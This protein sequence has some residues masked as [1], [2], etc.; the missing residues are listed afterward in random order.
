MFYAQGG[1]P[2][3]GWAT[4]VSELLIAPDMKAMLRSPLLAAICFACFTP[5]GS[6]AALDDGDAHPPEIRTPKSP[7]TPRINGPSIFGVRPG[8]FF[9]YH[10]PATGERP[11]Q[12]SAR[13]LPTGLQLDARSGE[14]TG[15]LPKAG[16]YRL[17]LHVKNAR[18]RSKKLFR[19]VVGETIA[20]T[21]PMGWNSWNCWG[22]KVDAEKVLKSARSMLVSGL[23][24][25]GWTYINI[26]DAWQGKRGGPFNAI[27]GNEKFPDMKGL[28]DTVHGMGLKIGI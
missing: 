20:L 18:G 11:M 26:D 28:C 22:G 27:Q 7:L 13:G 12:F 23:I 5:A 6:F 8:S 1:L 19:I 3:L 17:A 16:Q 21:P 24:N 10:I 15:W 25:H 4:D 9:L 2:V 14:I